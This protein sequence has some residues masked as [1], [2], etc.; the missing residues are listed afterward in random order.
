MDRGGRRRRRARPGSSRRLRPCERA[1]AREEVDRGRA[2]EGEKEG[3]GGRE[4][5]GGR[6][7]EEEGVVGEEG[8]APGNV[9]EAREKECMLVLAWW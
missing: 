4:E 7:R 6:R 5:R 2:K 9:A 8:G 1:Y 3:R